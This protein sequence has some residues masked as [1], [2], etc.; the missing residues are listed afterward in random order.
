MTNETMLFKTTTYYM[1]D[2]AE[3][4]RG[5]ITVGRRWKDEPDYCKTL[6]GK[7]LRI[8]CML[9]SF[10]KKDAY[11]VLKKVYAVLHIP[12]ATSEELQLQYYCSAFRYHNFDYLNCDYDGQQRY[13]MTTYSACGKPLEQVKLFFIQSKKQLFEEIRTYLNSCYG[14]GFDMYC[15]GK[16][17]IDNIPAYIVVYDRNLCEYTELYR[18]DYCEALGIELPTNN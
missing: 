10:V 9:C 15:E 17:A 13:V 14:M 3:L 18:K 8:F 12:L 7:L 6:P 11:D 2:I 1:K 16:T 4:C 5:G